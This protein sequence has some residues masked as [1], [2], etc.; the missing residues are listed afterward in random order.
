MKKTTT[1]K[2]ALAVAIFL[3]VGVGTIFSSGKTDFQ[4]D[5]V[6]LAESEIINGDY[7]GAAGVVDVAGTVNGDVMIAGGMINFS[8]KSSGDILAAGGE[9]K[10]SGQKEGNV[11][12][13]GGNIS[14]EGGIPKNV[15]VAGGSI[16]IEKNSVVDGS[17]YLAGGNIEIRGDVKGDVTAAGGRVLLAGSTNGDVEIWAEEI[18]IRPDARI[19]GNLIYHSKQ[20]ISVGENVVAG[21]I[22][23]RSLAVNQNEKKDFLGFIFGFE[24][25]RFLGMLILALILYKL[26]YRKGRD[27]VGSLEKDPWKNLAVGII[28]LILI[29]VFLVILLVSLVGWPLM[30]VVLFSFIIVLMISKIIAIITIGYLVNKRF[31]EKELTKKFPWINFILGYLIIMVLWIIPIIGW[32][33]VCLISAWSFGGVIW[34]LYKRFER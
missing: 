11:R 21:E 32:L 4:E 17:V 16:M 33:A 12:V 10:I 2:I 3:F 23:R 14:I 7:L 24:I 22:T 15:T 27:I 18:S 31:K 29:P 34:Y 9:I 1:K 19:G 20:E 30:F 6:F 13:A 26:F 25:I 5:E 8:G 28:S